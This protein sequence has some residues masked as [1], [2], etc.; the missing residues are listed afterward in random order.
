[1]GLSGVSPLQS[2]QGF[3]EY[4]SHFGM[5]RRRVRVLVTKLP[6]LDSVDNSFMAAVMV[7]R[8]IAEGAPNVCA[9]ALSVGEV[10][11]WEQTYLQWFERMK[12]RFPKKIDIESVKARSLEEFVRLRVIGVKLP[13]VVWKSSVRLDLQAAA[14]VSGEAK[15]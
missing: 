13:E 12:C 5:V 10:D 15:P 2:E 8:V 4:F 11:S 6:D 1:M 14:K 7:L 9:I 3:T